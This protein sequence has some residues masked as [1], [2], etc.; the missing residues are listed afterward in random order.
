MSWVD[1]KTNEEVLNMVQVDRK[2][3]NTIWYRTIQY[4]TI[5][6]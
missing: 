4:N 1:K 5:L 3:L 6:V 2:M